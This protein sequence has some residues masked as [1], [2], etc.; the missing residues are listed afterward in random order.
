MHLNNISKLKENLF[1]FKFLIK[2]YLYK[3][4][5]KLNIKFFYHLRYQNSV[6]QG[7]SVKMEK[8][9][10]KAE[11]NINEPLFVDL[12]F[13]MKLNISFGCW[14]DTFSTKTTYQSDI[15]N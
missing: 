7:T 9:N 2:E 14:K 10:R 15:G 12:F 1:N 6:F 8:V 11:K 3:K 4:S 13:E 5:L